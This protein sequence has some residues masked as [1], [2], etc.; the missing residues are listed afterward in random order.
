MA[1]MITSKTLVF[2]K[3]EAQKGAAET[4]TLLP[5]LAFDAGI[6]PA[7]P[8]IDRP[9][10]GKFMGINNPSV[11]GEAV[12]DWR[13]GLELRGNGSTAMDP[14]LSAMLKACGF[15][16]TSEVYTPCDPADQSTVTIQQY[17]D[18]TKKS[19]FGA[20]GRLKIEGET[21]K[22]AMCNFEMEGCW[23]GRVDEDLAAWTPSTESPLRVLA[24]TFT[25]GVT[26]RRISR[27]SLDMGNTVTPL[28]DPNAAAG[29]AYYVVS[30]RNPT[31]TIDPE[32]ELV[33]THDF[34]GLW[35]AG[36]P[37]AVVLVLGTG[38]GKRVTI[39]I[40]KLQYRQVREGDREN[41]RI[42]DLVGQCLISNGNDEVTIAV[43]T[44]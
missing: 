27:F 5:A 7:H 19:I 16:N 15:K 26:P 9:G 29:V 10:A 44:S 38:A 43:A 11:L 3:T 24:G 23:G 22:R 1:A 35:L 12:G 30:Q 28:Y 13:G 17:E 14:A 4:A 34:Y 41:L 21:G 25:L 32:D 40:P 2:V 18:G 42:N 39:T 6:N 31:L 20:A 33:V 37:V 36:T 8:V